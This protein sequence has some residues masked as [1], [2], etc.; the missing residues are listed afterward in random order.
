MHYKGIHELLR[1]LH[2]ERT[3][4]DRIEGAPGAIVVLPVLHVG[5]M[6]KKKG[7][8]GKRL[9]S[10]RAARLLMTFSHFKF[11]QRMSYA[12][13]RYDNTYVL[14]T[15]EPG[16]TKTC[17]FCGRWIKNVKLGDEWIDCPQYVLSVSLV[18]SLLRLAN[19]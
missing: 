7:K 10:D 19:L 18:N 11:R 14:F 16:T 13:R 4:G 6:V 9:L 3:I 8:D 15:E 1:K 5:A 17:V 12:V 2:V